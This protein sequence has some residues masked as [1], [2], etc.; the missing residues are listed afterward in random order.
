VLAVP[1][2]ATLRIVLGHFN[3]TRP[4]AN[5]LAGQLPRSD[6]APAKRDARQV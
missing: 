5:L 6:V 1:I 3:T 2:V 4:L